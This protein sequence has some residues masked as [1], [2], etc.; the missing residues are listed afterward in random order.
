MAVLHLP[1]S[2]SQMLRDL[3]EPSEQVVFRRHAKAPEDAAYANAMR[4]GVA[5]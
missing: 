3:C 4:N 2:P 5:A 1:F